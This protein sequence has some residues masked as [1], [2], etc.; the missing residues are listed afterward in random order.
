MAGAAVGGVGGLVVGGGV[1]GEMIAKNN[2]LKG[3]NEHFRQDYFHSMQLRILLGRAAQNPNFAER[4]NI[5]LEDAAG[6]A[7]FIGRAAKVGVATGNLVKSISIGVARGVGTVGLHVAGIVISVALVP[8]D[9]FQMIQSALRIHSK[10]KAEI[11]VD[12]ENIAADL[13]TELIPILK[14]REYELVKMER[15]DNEKKKHCLLLAIEKSSYERMS[16]N[17]SKISYDSVKNKH[18]VLLDHIGETLIDETYQRVVDKWIASPLLGDSDESENDEFD[19]NDEHNS[20]E[21]V[22]LEPTES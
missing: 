9:L 3:A 16:N 2:E 20:F 12:L 13:E 14:E 8:I 5:K 11:A 4:F 15:F 21:I 19:E 18:V 7:S 10:E 22:E 6:F 17:P 1:I